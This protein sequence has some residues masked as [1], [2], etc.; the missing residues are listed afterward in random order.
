LYFGDG[1]YAVTASERGTQ[2]ANYTDGVGLVLHAS[3][4]GLNMLA[5]DVDRG[6]D[7]TFWKYHFV[8][9]SGDANWTALASGQSNAIH[10]GDGE[11]NRVMVVAHGSHYV[12]YAND[13][14]L[15]SYQSTPSDNLPAFGEAGVFL[16]ETSITGVFAQYD[17]N[18]LPQT[19]WWEP[20]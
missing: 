16:N 2:P 6:G 5:F 14:F 12:F 7:W 17:I 20:I 3:A 11:A 13:R 4:D 10:T 19:S 9:K 18:S 8:D 1:A 15:G